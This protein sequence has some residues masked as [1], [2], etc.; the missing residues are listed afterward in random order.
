MQGGIMNGEF[1]YNL[2][3]K[4]EVIEGVYRWF[5]FCENC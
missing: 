3:L 2:A 4:G 1:I 5:F